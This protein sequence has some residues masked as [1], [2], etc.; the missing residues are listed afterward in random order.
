MLDAPTMA[1]DEATTTTAATPVTFRLNHLV[2]L[3]GFNHIALDGKLVRIVTNINE[4]T[5]DEE[6]DPPFFSELA[7]RGG[8]QNHMLGRAI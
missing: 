2:R 6:S 8:R 5:D 4:A 7:I 3:H 1:D